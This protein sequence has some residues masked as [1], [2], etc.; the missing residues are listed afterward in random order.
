MR[1]VIAP[2]SFK[3][4]LSAAAVAEA[5]AAGFAR[6][7]P[8]AAIVRKPVADGGE[9]TVEALVTAT[10]GRF[11]ETEA[12]GPLGRRVRARWGVLG[13]GATAVVEVAAA[14]GLELLTPAQRNPLRATSRGT[15]EL[16]R[17][18]LDA[19]CR[20]IIVGLGGSAVN[21]GGAG[22]ARALGARLLDSEGAELPDG[23][24]PLASLAR[25]DTS[26]LDP[27]LAETEI[28]G[29]TDVT[30][31]LLGHA[32]ASAMFGPQKGA[33]PDDVER[34]EAALAHYADIVARETG[35]DVRHVPGA[36]AAGGLGAALLA[37]CG[38]SLRSGADVVLSAVGLEEAI[39]DAT[40]VVTGEGKLD[41][42][43]AF[44]KAPLAVARLAKRHGKPV[45]A[46]AGILGDGVEKLY[47]MGID[48]AISIAPGP[49]TFHRSRREARRL[50]R[51]TGER[52]ARLLQVGLRIR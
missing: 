38:A 16:I 8:D 6:V 42:Q 22:M 19:G 3:G 52:L 47:A 50:L 44:G 41:R 34:L 21:D 31:P 48:A 32:G 13:D 2:D 23:A 9:G 5:L 12:T 27:R 11:V 17:A 7:W 14:S 39:R 29:A 43:T 18:A 24:A 51:D 30:N 37:F 46:V 28:I 26:G 40:L 36:G 49:I 35:R 25:I 1:I 4:S 45:V 10:G 20:R 33:S 15:G